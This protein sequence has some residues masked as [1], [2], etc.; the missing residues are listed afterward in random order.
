MAEFLHRLR[1][2][3]IAPGDSDEVKLRKQLLLFAM[4]LMTA[5][6]PLWLSLYGLLGQHVSSTLPVA[7][8]LA[9][10]LTLIIYLATLN[11]KFF[12]AA[13]LCLFLFSPFVL[14]WAQGDFHFSQRRR[15][16]GAAG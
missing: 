16:L 11:F 12:R 8:Q 5:V 1:T 3:G 13:Q 6:P 14:Q 15:A 2:A 9:S 10:L 7:Y 4:G